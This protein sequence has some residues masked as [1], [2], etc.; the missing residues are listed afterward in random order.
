[1]GSTNLQSVVPKAGHENKVVRAEISPDSKSIATASHDRTWKLWR[2]DDE[3]EDDSAATAS[4]SASA[5][6]EAAD[7]SMKEEQK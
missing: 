7:V 4:T 2:T 1:M 6:A 3:D 5:S